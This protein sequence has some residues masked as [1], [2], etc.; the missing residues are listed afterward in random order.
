MVTISSNVARIPDKRYLWGGARIA[1][2][3]DASGG[4]VIKQ[5]FSHG[6][7][8]GAAK[9]YYVRDHLGSVVGLVDDSGSVRGLWT[10]DLWGKRGAN[11]ITA[12]AVESD[13]GFTGHF[14]H[15]E[16]GL[17]TTLYRFYDPDTSRWLSRDL[18]GEMGPDGPNLYG[19]VRN[20]PVL[21][22]DENG[23]FGVVG[24]GVGFVTGFG[25]DIGFQMFD[26]Y[27]NGSPLG[28]NL[29]YWKAAKSGA[30]SVAAGAVGV[31]ALRMAGQT[32]SALKSAARLNKNLGARA[33]A[34]QAGKYRNPQTTAK[35][36]AERNSSLEEA[37][38]AATMG[39]VAPIVNKLTG[40]DTKEPCK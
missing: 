32:G 36:V 16:S 23:E 2:E 17:V 31:P 39:A 25:L 11:Q 5:Y 15:T 3:R 30:F 21:Y 10:Y 29:D 22:I 8:A 34:V 4:T 18:I 20:N 9:Y 38:D 19:Y 24:A 37:A 35:Q 26:N 33:K 13:L 6:F 7:Q 27:M 28:C 1:E 12:S 40:G 14:L